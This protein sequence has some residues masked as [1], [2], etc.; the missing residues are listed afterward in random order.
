MTVVEK[1]PQ[2]SFAKLQPAVNMVGNRAKILTTIVQQ[3]EVQSPLAVFA[4]QQ[5]TPLN[6]PSSKNAKTPRISMLITSEDHS[7]GKKTLHLKCVPIIN[8]SPTSSPTAKKRKSCLSDVSSNAVLQLMRVAPSSITEKE[9]CGSAA[10]KKRK[11]SLEGVS[12]IS[13]TGIKRNMSSPSKIGSRIQDPIPRK[14]S[15]NDKVL[16]VERNSSVL[17]AEMK[18]PKKS[19]RKIEKPI[20]E[21]P[22]SSPN[23]SDGDSPSS[24]K[25]RGSRGRSMTSSSGSDEDSIR[26][27]HNVLER[28]RREGLRHLYHVLRREIPELAENDRAAKVV[29]LKKAKEHVMELEETH[30]ML[31]IK[32]EEEEQKRQCLK[33]RLHELVAELTSV[34]PY[35][36]T[37]CERKAKPTYI[38]KFAIVSH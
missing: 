10:E 34:A 2:G 17:L 22:T 1:K 28:Q 25:Q 8:A 24:P 30:E 32:K 4:T 13:D 15:V 37:H 6:G 23:S 14:L 5:K 35:I 3:S 16:K 38:D 19:V 21:S 7:K 18:K 9:H 12:M 27:A 11:L 26:A 29:I 20:Y 36:S 31:R 33:Q